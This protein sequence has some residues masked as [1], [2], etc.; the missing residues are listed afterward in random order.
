MNEQEIKARHALQQMARRERLIKTVHAK[1]GWKF[2]L[3]AVLW[4][5]LFALLGRYFMHTPQGDAVTG[6]FCSFFSVLLLSFI[7]LHEHFAKK[8]DALLTLLE[9]VDHGSEN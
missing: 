1:P 4:L 5:S 8:F 9:D 6:F 2:L 3:L 7:T